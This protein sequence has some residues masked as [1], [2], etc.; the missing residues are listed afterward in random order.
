[1]K[2]VPFLVLAVVL[3]AVVL[4]PVAIARAASW[5][6]NA[7]KTQRIFPDGTPA[8]LKILYSQGATFREHEFAL[9]Q[10]MLAS[11]TS[12][13]KIFHASILSGASIPTRSA[14]VSRATTTSSPPPSTTNGTSNTGIGGN[15][16][17][18]QICRYRDYGV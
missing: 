8:V 15:K 16:Y 12:L 17:D 18:D 7:D 5:K 9:I 1:M 3:M 10:P 6:W 11:T 14:R 4:A 2:R 13:V